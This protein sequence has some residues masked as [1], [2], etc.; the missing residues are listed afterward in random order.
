INKTFPENLD[1]E[2][3]SVSPA[4][5]F[6]LIVVFG[7]V[8]V[9]LLGVLIFIVLKHR[10]THRGG[11]LM[12]VRLDSLPSHG[13]LELNVHPFP[14]LQTTSLPLIKQWDIR[15]F[16]GP[17][18]QSRLV[19]MDT[20]KEG[21]SSGRVNSGHIRPRGGTHSSDAVHGYSMNGGTFRS[22]G[23]DVLLGRWFEDGYPELR[24]TLMPSWLQ[25]ALQTREMN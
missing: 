22:P 5:F 15:W 21:E 7:A 14:Y 17:R 10:K 19:S 20:L 8:I 24:L 9:F 3:G 18:K 25:K 1:K 16:P 12:S 23:S 2:T 11:M 13:S 6:I 4:V